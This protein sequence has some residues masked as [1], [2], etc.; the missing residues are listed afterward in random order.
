MPTAEMRTPEGMEGMP[1]PQFRPEQEHGEG[2]FII[3]FSDNTI[4]RFKSRMEAAEA[5][6]EWRRQQ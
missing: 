2:E 3:T 6:D 4:G 1:P 5:L